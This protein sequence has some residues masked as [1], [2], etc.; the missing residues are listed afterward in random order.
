MCP[1]DKTSAILRADAMRIVGA[2]IT[3][4]L[5]DAAVK[6]ALDGVRFSGQVV[7]IAIGKAAWRMAYAAR[8]ALG[9]VV[10]RGV[11][12]TKYRHSNGPIGNLEIIEAG[13]PVPDENSYLAAERA[14]EAVKGLSAD[15]TVLFL[16]SGGGSALF[17]K[18]LVSKRT[19][20]KL[21]ADLLACG[22]DITEMNTVRKRLSA[23]KGGRFAEYCAPA[24]IFCAVLS[25][26]VGDPL[27]MIASGPVYP[28]STTSAQALGII[29]KYGIS[30]D[31]DALATLSL[32]TPKEIA[33]ARYTVCGSVGG[34][35]KAAKAECEKLGYSARIV[36]T[37]LC[38][39]ARD[40]GVKLAEKAIDNLNSKKPLAFIYGGETV[41][42][43]VG[44]GKGGRNQEV[45]LAAAQTLSGV[46][47]AAVI[48]VGSDGTD[49]PTDAAGGYADGETADRISRTGRTA[50]EYLDN[51]DSFSAL[52]AAGGLV[53]TGATGTNVNDLS[54]VL[55][56]G[57]NKRRM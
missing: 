4:S 42:K 13:H 54:V 29:E 49:G 1:K 20:E 43:I 25:D 17:E 6:R 56:A 7:T 16:V 36:T 38:C 33:N 28:D 48:A 52:E 37:S 5:P 45:A 18:P 14:I 57:C 39:F 9:D 34:L 11:V 47:N 15:D 12:A 53:F 27:D 2:A 50:R 35:C 22:A 8:E 3:A 44:S 55:V 31:E 26:I 21:N 30:L 23:V 40:A 24:K 32:E 51:N 41:V 46:S 19:I 10:D